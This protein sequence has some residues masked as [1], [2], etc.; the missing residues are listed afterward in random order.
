V[1]AFKD[2]EL[3]RGIPYVVYDGSAKLGW[4][5][6]GTTHV[7]AEFAVETIRRW[8]RKMALPAYPAATHC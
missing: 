2:K 1:H 5:S 7:M 6:F 8:W 4:V 3:G